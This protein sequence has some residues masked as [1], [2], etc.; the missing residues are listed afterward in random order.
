VRPSTGSGQEVRCRSRSDNQGEGCSAEGVMGMGVKPLPWRPF[1]RLKVLSDV[2]GEGNIRGGG[3]ICVYSFTWNLK[4]VVRQ[5][6]DPELVEVEP[7]TVFTTLS[8]PAV[9][10]TAIRPVPF[11]G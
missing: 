10:G 5:A 2:E 9:P 1:G 4:L 6:H 11:R 8:P 7:G 3:N